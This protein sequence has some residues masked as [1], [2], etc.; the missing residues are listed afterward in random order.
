MLENCCHGPARATGT[1]GVSSEWRWSSPCPDYYLEIFWAKQSLPEFKIT[2][3][4]H[5]KDVKDHSSRTLL[6]QMGKLKL[7]EKGCSYITQRQDSKLLEKP[8]SAPVIDTGAPSG[9]FPTPVTIFS[10]FH[11]QLI[12]SQCLPQRH[13]H[14]EPR[15]V[16]LF[17]KR[18]FVGVAQYILFRISR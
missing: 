4:E 8:P 10:A 14:L 1:A 13:A 15:I 3:H 5:W 2:G 9:C 17:G 18:V 16:T 12:Q 6:F 11:L 7:R